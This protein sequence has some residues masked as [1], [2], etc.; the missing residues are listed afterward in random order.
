MIHRLTSR[1][2]SILYVSHH[3][4]E[5]FELA[6][7]V[8]VLRD[9]RARRP[10]VGELDHGRLVELIV[11]HRSS[12]TRATSRRRPARCSACAS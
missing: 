5:V 9:G 10:P 7:R 12:N 2:V 1:G 8:T 4:D 3:L 11:G 6:D